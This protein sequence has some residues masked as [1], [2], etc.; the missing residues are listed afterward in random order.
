MASPTA[1]STIHD[2]LVAQW[3][4]STPLVFENETWSP[5][6]T[7]APFV[8]VEIYGSQYDQASIGGGDPV[9]GN[10]WREIGH[11]YGHV[12]IPNG[13]GSLAGRQLCQQFV[14]LFRG[15][16][17]GTVVFE[18][19]SIGASAPGDQDGNYYRMTATLD[20]SRDE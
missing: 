3:G 4:T 20:W 13:T 8:V 15:R 11:L 14:D 2:Y 17:I 1:F 12:L 6:D 10:L 7:P 18:G 9:N 19:G 5:P 16:E